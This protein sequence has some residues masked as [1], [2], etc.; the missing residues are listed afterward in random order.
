M[1]HIQSQELAQ[2]F[3]IE[4]LGDGL[5]TASRLGSWQELKK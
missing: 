2:E 3:L 1:I 5:L 4:W